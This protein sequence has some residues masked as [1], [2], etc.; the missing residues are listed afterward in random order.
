MIDRA[1]T[2]AAYEQIR[3]YF[4]RPDA[5]QAFSE[6]DGICVYRGYDE[7][8]NRDPYSP[9]RCALGVLIPDH[10]Y[11]PTFERTSLFR[12]KDREEF[13][14]VLYHL[15][16]VDLDFVEQAQRQHDTRVFEFSTFIERLDQEA[17]NFGLT[18]PTKEI[19]Q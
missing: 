9:I 16:G 13:R 18:T 10:L 6:K 12:L 4:T 8:G 17:E 14:D 15:R 11:Q 3:A 2:Q 19:S 7:H 1:K 5:A